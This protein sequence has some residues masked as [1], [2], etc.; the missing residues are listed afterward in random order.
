MCRVSFDR[1]LSPFRHSAW[2]ARRGLSACSAKR[3]QPEE[4][5]CCPPERRD[6]CH[7]AAMPR[8]PS[9]RPSIVFTCVVA[10]REVPATLLS[11][12]LS[13]AHPYVR[14]KANCVWEQRRRNVVPPAR[15]S[16]AIFPAAHRH[17]TEAC[18]VVRRT[19]L[20]PLGQAA[21]TG[22]PLPYLSARS[23][24]QRKADAP[25]WLRQG[26][27]GSSEAQSGTATRSALV[28]ALND[29]SNE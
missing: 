23:P 1:P 11:I 8:A 28:S 24:R 26:L 21:G 6:S 2:H 22:E 15:T 3:P 12:S 16:P 14:P 19:Q 20:N 10:L 9:P 18:F 7:A 29:E 4:G 13:T 25:K 5:T 17:M 27:T